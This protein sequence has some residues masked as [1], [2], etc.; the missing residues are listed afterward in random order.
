MNEKKVS[1]RR[2][3]VRNFKGLKDVTIEFTDL[4]SIFGKNGAGK[5]TVMDA[6][7]WLLFGKNSQYDT[8]FSIKP[9]DENGNE[10]HHLETDVVGI[11]DIDG[12]ETKLQ[13]ILRE[14]WVTKRGTTE[15]VYE[16]NETT[17]FIN[18]APKKQVDYKKYISTI[19]DE[20]AFMLV[21]ST[22]YFQTLEW[23]ER[24]NILID[25]IGGVDDNVVLNAVKAKVTTASY[26]RLVEILNSK[27]SLEDAKA[28]IAK[29]RLQTEKELNLMPARIDECMLGMPEPKDF[30][31]LRAQE[32]ALVKEIQGIDAAILDRSR[33]TDA[34]VEQRTLKLKE[35]QACSEKITQRIAV[36]R[37]TA[38]SEKSVLDQAVTDATTLVNDNIRLVENQKATNKVLFEALTSK[39]KELDDLRATYDQLNNSSITFDDGQFNCPSCKR[40]FEEGDIDAQKTLLTTNF[41]NDK[42]QRLGRMNVEGK[43]LKELVDLKEHDYQAANDK[44]T[45]FENQLENARRAL[46]TAKGNVASY[47]MPNVE[48]VIQD[49]ETYKSLNIEKAALQAALPKIEPVDTSDLTAS[50][51]TKEAALKEVREQLF[52]E[53]QIAIDTK[54]LEE[55]KAKELKMAQEKADLEQKEFAIAAFV[56]ERIESVEGK[57]NA[58]F[59]MVKFRMFK[60]QI[61]GG[62]KEDCTT[63]IKGV[64]YNDAN[65]AAK[66]NAGLDIVNTLSKFYGIKAPVFV[67]QR[68][69]VN[70]LLPSESQIINLIV[71]RDETLKVS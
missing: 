2:L 10:K 60:P 20:R 12:D 55:L 13:R 38:L 15:K 57:I 58:C 49:D 42:L 61:N 28:A 27:Q 33:S 6:F 7:I 9:L 71:T 69:S 45:E 23:P 39:R 21:S 30:E 67:D 14:K 1:L 35:V 4:T 34:I 46:E 65:T 53:K 62:E 48:Q 26:N 36:I 56:K 66:V 5:S 17:Y 41:N 52:V 63:M 31:S 47:V 3:I 43:A 11:I 59:K 54:R 40:R 24:R 29:Q 70:D 8:V 32:A 44:Q 50:K 68:E 19:M 25:L 37:E 18:D 16:G 22:N 51:A 64:P